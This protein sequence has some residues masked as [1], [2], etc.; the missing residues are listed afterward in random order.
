MLKYAMC[1]IDESFISWNMINEQNMK[2]YLYFSDDANFLDLCKFLNSLNPVTSP[3]FE[4]A[5]LFVL[6]RDVPRVGVSVEYDI[7]DVGIP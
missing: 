5:A 2:H 1:W 4:E 6:L 3:F 7:L